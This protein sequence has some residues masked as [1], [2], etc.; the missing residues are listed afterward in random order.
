MTAP[1]AV[2]PCGLEWIETRRTLVRA[3]DAPGGWRGW[4]RKLF[5][6]HVTAPFAPRHREFWSHV[7]SIEPADSPRPF[8]GIWP[9]G[10]AKST[11]AELAAVALGARGKR[12]YCWYV[13]GTQDQADNSVANIAALLESD[14]V[15]AHYPTHARRK[16]G[17]FGASRGWR[18]N[19]LRTDGGFTVDAIGLDRAARGAKV[20][21][22]RPD[23]I[24]LD[25]LDA[26]HDTPATTAK[27][28]ATLTTSLLPAGAANV[29]II[30][31]QNLIIPDGIFTRMVDGRAEYLSERIVS[32]PYPALT[33][34]VFGYH[35]DDVSGVRVPV[36]RKGTAT[37]AGQG[38][39]AC[40]KLLSIIGLAAFKKE[41]QHDVLERREGLA[42]RFDSRRHYADLTFDQ[43]QALVKL[44]AIFA[45]VDFQAWRFAFVLYAADPAGVIYRIGEIFSQLEG[46]SERAQKIHELCA[47]FGILKRIPLWG[48]AANPQD[49]MELNAA[50]KRGWMDERGRHV[51]SMLRCAPVGSENKMRKASVERWNDLLTRGAFKLVRDGPWVMTGD[52]WRLGW[53][54]G[55]GGTEME[56]SRLAWEI[57]HWAYP[58]PA[59]GKAQDDSPNDHTAD[60]ADAIAA[61]RYAIMSWW[62]GAKI[63]EQE[64]RGAWD[65]DVLKE[66][67]DYAHRLGPRLQRRKKKV[68]VDSMFG[69][70]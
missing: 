24:I 37:W 49:I 60:G 41:C 25:D 34:A 65:P 67:A 45:G 59:D 69:A 66:D 7:W 54:A 4:L 35:K 15:S 17:K 53:N 39:K 33:Q 23:L 30:A 58:V 31:I 56:G 2:H 26:K 44:G 1:V 70:Y 20:E 29:C 5:P 48:D 12:R 19:R 47:R 64:E 68:M 9:R 61:S 57:L 52:V 13:R 42:L 6:R 11:S 28:I 16:L 43:I 10:G 3:H 36:I 51:T 38:L 8:V 63:P 50:F 27:K 32:G 62:K 22:Q 40:A 18:R 55:A 14:A 21:E 46:L